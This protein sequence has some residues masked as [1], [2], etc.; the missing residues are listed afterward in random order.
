MNETL[1]DNRDY[2][3]DTRDKDR[4][5]EACKDYIRLLNKTEARIVAA[6][7][8]LRDMISGAEEDRGHDSAI[9]A[10]IRVLEGEANELH[11]RRLQ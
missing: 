2:D 5:F 4:Y 7:N 11:I 3:R 8:D 1:E 6:L 9:S 10:I